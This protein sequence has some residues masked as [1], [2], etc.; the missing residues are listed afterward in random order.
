MQVIPDP[1]GQI[2]SAEPG[3]RFRFW[4][5]VPHGM[6]PASRLQPAAFAYL[7]DWWLNFCIFVPQI[8]RGQ[9]QRIYVASL[10]HSVW[11]HAPP[12]ADR[13]LHVDT[14]CLYSGEG[15]GLVMAQFHDRDGRHV[16]T[17][18]QECLTTY[19]H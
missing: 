5:K 8:R 13:W 6:G 19:P 2:G 16:A 17:A 14:K 15:R 7:S 4:C 3:G 18:N 11:L 10:N 12:Q 1:L 9:R